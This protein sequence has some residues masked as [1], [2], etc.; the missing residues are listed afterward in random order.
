LLISAGREKLIN[1][2]K[3]IFGGKGMEKGEGKEKAVAENPRGEG[4]NSPEEEV[5]SQ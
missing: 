5:N 1:Q 3:N 4:V 2:R